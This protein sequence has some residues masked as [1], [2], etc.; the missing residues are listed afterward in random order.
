MINERFA[1]SKRTPEGVLH[2]SICNLFIIMQINLHYIF[3]FVNYNQNIN[4]RGEVC[5]W[6]IIATIIQIRI[7]GIL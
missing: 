1:A 3:T 2:F 7:M 4:A 5:I 6:D